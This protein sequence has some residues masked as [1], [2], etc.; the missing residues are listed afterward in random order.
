MPLAGNFGLFSSSI[1][2]CFISPTVVSIS[3]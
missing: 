3:P 2:V 1:N